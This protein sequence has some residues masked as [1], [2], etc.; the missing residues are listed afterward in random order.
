MKSAP[1]R[2]WQR[3]IQKLAT[4]KVI[5]SGFLSKYL[6]HIDTAVLKW[7]NGRATLTTSLSGLP[8]VTLI[9]TGAK[10]GQSRKVLLAGY[11]DGDDIFLVA[12]S[13]GSLNY[14]AW[15][16]NLCAHPQVQV[17]TNGKTRTYEA[18]VVK[19]GDRERY[20]QQA[21]DYYPGYRAYEQRSGGR[22]I[23][24]VLLKLAS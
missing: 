9:T 8:V 1:I 11:P 3:I 10:S 14:P 13:F 18:Q 4:T 23:P 15:Y 22:E 19:R 6:H 7:S 20:W 5:S 17:N 16:H 12:S 2:W 24:I 21:L